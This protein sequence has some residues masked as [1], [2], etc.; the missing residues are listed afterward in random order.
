MI[1]SL[2]EANDGWW[3]KRSY[4]VWE[5]Q[6]CPLE[7]TAEE[8]IGDDRIDDAFETVCDAIGDTVRKKFIEFTDRQ[9]LDQLAVFDELF[10]KVERDPAWAC[11]EKLINMPG[12]FTYLLS[13]YKEGYF[14]CS[15]DGEYPL[16]RAVVL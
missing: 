13:I 14:T 6:I 10:E 11:V 9:K 5:S 8:I 1:F 3:G 15:W 7:D 16:G 4:E 12:F 2:Y